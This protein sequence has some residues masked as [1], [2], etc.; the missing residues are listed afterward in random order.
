MLTEAGVEFARHVGGSL[1]Y[2]TPHVDAIYSSPALRCVQTAS[3]YSEFFN[4]R[5]NVEPALFEPVAYLPR[6]PTVRWRTIPELARAGLRVNEMFTPHAPAAPNP[7]AV[8][9]ATA[10]YCART[11]TLLT[12][13]ARIHAGGT[14]LLVGHASSFYTVPLM[15]G[16]PQLAEPSFLQHCI[17]HSGSFFDSI[18]SG[19]KLNE[20]PLCGLLRCSGRVGEWRL[21]TGFGVAVRDGAMAR[22]SIA[23]TGF[24]TLS[25][26]MRGAEKYFGHTLG[27]AG[28]G[29]IVF[30]AR[31]YETLRV[32][33]NASPTCSRGADGGDPAG[34]PAGDGAAVYCFVIGESQGFIRRSNRGGDV[35]LAH[36]SA[37]GTCL[38]SRWRQYWVSLDA[39]R[40]VVAMGEGQPHRKTTLLV[41]MDASYLKDVRY[42]G[43]ANWTKLVEVKEVYVGPPPSGLPDG[44]LGSEQRAAVDAARDAW[45]R[46]DGDPSK[47]D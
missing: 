31:G 16:S 1:A 24:I 28:N 8:D 36:S 2:S 26:P 23:P 43:F 34:A 42:V 10:E 45:D 17:A 13:L 6:P 11:A 30:S 19:E 4:C 21:D 18:L 3:I 39:S 33:V 41:A 20:V 5:V 38:S 9:T 47:K 35:S 29:S 25:S 22:A 40:G 12:H 27:M 15:L 14:V 7:A 32:V 46:K 44:W 37:V